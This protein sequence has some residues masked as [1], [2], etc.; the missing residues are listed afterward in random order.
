MDITFLNTFDTKVFQKCPTYYALPTE[1][2]N[3]FQ[4]VTSSGN[5]WDTA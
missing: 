4:T 1:D 5:K 2:K 3:N